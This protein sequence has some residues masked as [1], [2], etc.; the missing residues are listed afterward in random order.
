[1]TNI[2]N[3]PLR[4]TDREAQ[5][6]IRERTKNQIERLERRIHELEAQKPY[7]DLQVVVRA[8]EAIEAENAE[9]KRRLASIIGMLQP[10]VG[11][12]KFQ[13][14]VFVYGYTQKFG[15]SNKSR[16]ARHQ[17]CSPIRRSPYSYDNNKQH[18]LPPCSIYKFCI[19]SRR[20][21]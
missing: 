18:C 5:R 10:L 14:S 17:P 3:L 8:K 11:S 9:I 20:I 12:S 16:H 4:C 2:F 7:Q 15:E 13:P 19:S 21:S 6:A 1:M